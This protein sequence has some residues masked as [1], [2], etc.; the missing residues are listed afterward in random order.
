MHYKYNYQRKGKGKKLTHMLAF[1][2]TGCNELPSIF[3][4]VQ[5]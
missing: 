4:A 5:N 1:G 3:E 2:G